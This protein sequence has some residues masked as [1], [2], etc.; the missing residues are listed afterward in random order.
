[1]I[2][3]YTQPECR[4]CKRVIGKFEDAGVPLKVIDVSVDPIAKD[5]VTRWLQ[6]TSVPVIEADHL[7]KPIIGYQPD[8]VKQLILDITQEGNNV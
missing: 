3:V 8:L 4:A 7:E 2:T 1:M 5:Y 6:A